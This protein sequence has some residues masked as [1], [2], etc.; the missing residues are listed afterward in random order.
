MSLL[1]YCLFSGSGWPLSHAW[2]G[3][4]GW[5]VVMEYVL[6]CHSCT[7]NYDLLC[8]LAQSAGL[9]STHVAKSPNTRSVSA[10]LSLAATVRKILWS[11]VPCATSSAGTT[12]RQ[13]WLEHLSEKVE[14]RFERDKRMDIIGDVMNILID[15]LAG[16]REISCNN[17][18]GRLVSNQC[19]ES[20][21][22]TKLRKGEP[23]QSALIQQLISSTIFTSIQV[24]GWV[25]ECRNDDADASEAKA[26]CIVSPN[27]RQLARARMLRIVPP[28]LEC[29]SSLTEFSGARTGSALQLNALKSYACSVKAS[30]ASCLY[31]GCCHVG[32]TNL[33][34]ISDMALPTK[35]CSRCRQTR[36]CSAKCQKADWIEG[37]HSKICQE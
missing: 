17:V 31:S 12:L 33:D 34:G 24:L 10:C 18:Q 7:D 13:D 15:N 8:C 3:L 2:I 11:L 9:A 28:L 4:P 30:C 25:R 26:D 35:L 19:S 29:M 16:I 14:S 37:G 1:L 22:Q 21:L 23:D 5:A 36:Y 27:P 20:G 6:R 32:C